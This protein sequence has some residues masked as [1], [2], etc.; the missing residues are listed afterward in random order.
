MYIV[1]V[2]ISDA[3]RP[4]PNESQIMKHAQDWH[5]SQS[6]QH[7]KSPSRHAVQISITLLVPIIVNWLPEISLNKSILKPKCKQY[8]PVTYLGNCGLSWWLPQSSMHQLVDH[9]S[10]L[11]SDMPARHS[12]PMHTGPFPGYQH[13]HLTDLCLVPW[14]K[15]SCFALGWNIP[16]CSNVLC[17][18]SHQQHTVGCTWSQY[19]AA[20]WGLTVKVLVAMCWSEDWKITILVTSSQWSNIN[21]ALWLGEYCYRL[22]ISDT[23][24]YQCEKWVLP[25]ISYMGTFHPIGYLFQGP[26]NRPVHTIL[27]FCGLSP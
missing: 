19:Q 9:T 2:M 13:Q 21:A 26:L 17:H 27:H 18:L 5:S 1:I 11:F 12:H 24:S 10:P 14:H 3:V 7:S 6:F 16:H 23:V 4:N 8:W 25:Y 20:V 15:S 22:R